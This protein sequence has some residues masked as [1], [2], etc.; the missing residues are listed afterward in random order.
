M[1]LFGQRL[2]VDNFLYFIYSSRGSQSSGASL[3]AEI[4][5]TFYLRFR[6]GNKPGKI[7]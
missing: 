6:S 4:A 3:N 2:G 5:L 1:E 7:D